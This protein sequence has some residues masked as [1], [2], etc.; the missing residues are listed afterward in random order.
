MARLLPLGQRI[1]LAL[2]YALMIW[3]TWLLLF[4]GALAQARINWDRCAGHRGLYGHLL[5]VGRGV[6]RGGRPAAGAGPVAH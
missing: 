6:C 4:S 2:S 3:C 1:C 5:C